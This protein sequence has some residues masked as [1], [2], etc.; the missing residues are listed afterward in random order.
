MEHLPV[1]FSVMEL[2]V[3]LLLFEG[4]VITVTEARVLGVVVVLL[5]ELVALVS[6]HRATLH[7]LGQLK[8]LE[9]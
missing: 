2:F 9:G 8:H 1:L 3:G 6:V 7:L 4:S 5:G